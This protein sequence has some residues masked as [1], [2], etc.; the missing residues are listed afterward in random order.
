MNYL[1]RK[2][3]SITLL[4]GFVLFIFLSSCD[5]GF[6]EMNINPNVYTKPVYGSLFSQ[7]VII[8]AGAGTQISDPDLA[9]T[10]AWVQ[11]LASLT[12]SEFYGDKYLWLPGN[13][14]R[15]WLQAYANELKAPI[16]II[17]FLKDNPDMVNQYNI[18]RIWKVE[19]F[20]RITDMYG[21]VPYFDA[22][23]G[24]I[25]GIFN[26][27]YDKQKDIYADMLKE[28]EE[29]ALALDPTK[30]SFGSADYLYSGN[31]DKWKKFSYSLML[32]LGM[33]LTKV[34]PAMAEL[35]VKKAIA[36]GVMQSNAD[37]AKLAHTSETSSNWNINT[38]YLQQKFIPLSVKGKTSVKLNKT[39]VDYL[40]STQD[41]RLPFYA[42]LWQGN[43]NIAD[44]PAYSQIDLQKGLP[45]GQDY[46][47]IK[48]LIPSW[49]DNSITEYSEWNIYKVGHYN[50]PTV[51][52]S[53]SEVEYLQAEAE[54]RGWTT[55]SSVKVHYEKGVRA[56]ILLQTIYP[57]AITTTQANAAADA[58]LAAN[59]YVAGSFEE[60]MSQIHTQFW[61]SQF[62]CSNQEAWAN[63]RRTGYPVLKPYNYLGN[64]TGGIIP[65]RIVYSATDASVNTK[66]YTDAVAIQGPDDFMTRVWWDKE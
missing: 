44:L 8:H 65:R 5:K 55:G 42:T 26:P 15:F 46:T 34:D 25:N 23:Y 53:Y 4:A 62:M 16:Q 58:Y 14:E 19:V 59:P 50:A 10:G 32:R 6:E 1:K 27:K 47:S 33:R 38:Q 30:S 41:P 54:L 29:A 57:N 11:Y 7:A 45:G 60:Q 61:V 31:T 12:L 20:H 28:L 48:S 39:F 63:W 64:I 2:I 18:M 21:D 49:N 22:G 3:T 66:N 35:W 56:S 37:L 52:Q 24:A 36:G 43:A 51:F 40:K 17:S 13:Y 9:Q